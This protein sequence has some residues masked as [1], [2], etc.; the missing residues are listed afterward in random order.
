MFSMAMD[1][2][3]LQA[4]CAHATLSRAEAAREPQTWKRSATWA[5]I[6]QVREPTTVTSAAG[7]P[8]A[9]RMRPVQVASSKSSALCSGGKM[10]TCA[11]HG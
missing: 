11:G 9:A 3:N 2:S 5:L 6:V 1:A 7:S 10:G 8:R 4:S